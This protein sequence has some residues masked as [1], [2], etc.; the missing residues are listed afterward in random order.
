MKSGPFEMCRRGYY[1]IFS[2]ELTDVNFKEYFRVMI[3]YFEDIFALL[4]KRFSSFLSVKK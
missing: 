3:L 2:R 1:K 4:T